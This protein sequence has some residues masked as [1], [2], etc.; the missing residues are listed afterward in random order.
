MS[1]TVAKYSQFIWE[2]LAIKIS[3]IQT[4]KKRFCFLVNSSNYQAVCLWICPSIFLSICLYLLIW[5]STY[6]SVC[7][8]V[9][10]SVYCLS[11]Y[12]SVCLSVSLSFLVSVSQS[13]THFL[14]IC[15]FMCLFF[16][17]TEFMQQG[18]Y[19]LIWD[20]LF[21]TDIC[22]SGGKKS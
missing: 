20:H 1:K 18:K 4:T 13:M 6:L 16:C 14:S 8:S 15:H 21:S 19:Y 7:L 22:V 9:C 2:L 12:L 11:L 3:W 5:L 10:L 17:K